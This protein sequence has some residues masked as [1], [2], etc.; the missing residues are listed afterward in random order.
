[1]DTPKPPDASDPLSQPTRARLFD[2]LG[3]LKRAAST[4]ELAEL[5][6]IHPNSVRLHLGRLSAAGLV[7]R[8]LVP[9]AR[10][11]PHHEWRIS[12]GARPAGAKPQAYEDLARW[13]AQLLAD[14]R[15][16]ADEIEAA[17]EKIG[18]D[19]APDRRSEGTAGGFETALAALGFQPRTRARGGRVVFRLGNCPYRA[20][21]GKRQPVVCTL[22]RGLARG[23]IEALDPEARM[24]GFV[25]KDP[26]QAGCVIEIELP[27]AEAG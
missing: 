11:R 12:P 3:S 13:L 25:A 19:L 1:M 7:E 8:L 14:G 4:E 20:A 2:L 21:V 22:H 5:A 27:D 16:E 18:R 26:R 10:G 9:G 6:A 17:A 23:M 24:T 15:S